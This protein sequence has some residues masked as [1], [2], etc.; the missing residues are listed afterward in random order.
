MKIK[1]KQIPLGS[2][3]DIIKLKFYLHKGEV[4]RVSI[5]LV[6]EINE[7]EECIL[8]YDCSHGFLHKDLCY[9]KPARKEVIHENLN[10]IFV[11]NTISHLKKNFEKYKHYYKE[12]YL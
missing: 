7:A 1:E 6:C 12:N 2:E 11:N 8:R 10:H 3:K 5:A 4:I 9:A